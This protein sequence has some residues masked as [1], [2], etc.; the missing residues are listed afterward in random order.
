MVCVVSAGSSATISRRLQLCIPNLTCLGMS[1]RASCTFPVALRISLA[2]RYLDKY[3]PKRIAERTIF[4]GKAVACTI[5]M[6]AIAAVA[7]RELSQ[8]NRWTVFSGFLC[9]MSFPAPVPT[10]PKSCQN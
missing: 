9:C 5:S 2:Y 3:L 7:S 6:M 8:S 4:R 10:D 1:R